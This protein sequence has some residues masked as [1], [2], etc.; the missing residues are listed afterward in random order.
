MFCYFRGV[1][2]WQLSFTGN[3]TPQE[4]VHEPIDETGLKEVLCKIN[5]TFY[6][7]INN[8]IQ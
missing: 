7:E 3:K 6:N 2:Y 4:T 1:Y 5:K 8:F